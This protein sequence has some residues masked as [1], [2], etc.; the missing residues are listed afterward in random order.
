M[1]TKPKPAP[2][3]A[4][5]LSQAT[6]W[7]A[8]GCKPL[9]QAAARGELKFHALARR[10]YPG[11][12]LPAGMLPEVSSLGF[13]D[14]A[15]S[16]SWGLDWHRNEGIELT[17][18]SR[19][20]LD[21]AVDGRACPLESGCLTITRPWQ[22]HRVGNPNVRA[23][24]LHWLILD[25]GVRRPNQDWQW[26]DWLILSPDDLRQLTNLLRHNEHPVWKVD[27]QIGHCFERT[28]A[29]VAMRRPENAQTRLRLHLN[30]LLVSVLEMLQSRKVTLDEKLST[31]RRT[32]EMFLTSL[33]HQLH[34]PW[35]LD[36]MA[37]Q[38]GLGRTRFAD[39]CHQ[40]ANAAP[41]EY[42]L[43]CRV[44]AARRLLRLESGQSI[45]DI[46]FAC[47][48]QS[49]QYFTTVFH[50]RTGLSPRDFRRHNTAADKPIDPGQLRMETRWPLSISNCPLHRPLPW[51][52]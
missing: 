4:V 10:G 51:L 3:P 34:N 8:D 35:T 9:V 1:R 37:A 16:Q 2:R 20:R 7:H 36:E 48:F 5:F 49:S 25:V 32:V 44:E 27:D 52:K 47:G 50:R 43:N 41:M 22:A 6:A 18:L 31:T 19:G 13:W 42:L 33:P 39:Y 15:T 28:A 17:Y 38:C 21:F 45:S 30:E 40:I 46:G 14:A 12:A 11:K 26:P 24:R 29:L 23:S